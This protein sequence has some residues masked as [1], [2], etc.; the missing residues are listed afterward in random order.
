MDNLSKVIDA[1]ARID[2]PRLYE[3]WAGGAHDDD[4]DDEDG[5]DDVPV[6]SP[7][8]DSSPKFFIH[9]PIA[10]LWNRSQ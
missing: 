8:A 3:F 6:S 10:P 1:Y 9:A 5:V 2:D 4:T 7:C